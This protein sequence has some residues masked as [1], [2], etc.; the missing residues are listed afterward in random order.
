MQHGEPRTDRYPWFIDKLFKLTY[1][2]ISDISIAGSSNS[3]IASRL[4]KK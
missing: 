3:Y 4:N 1:T 2:C